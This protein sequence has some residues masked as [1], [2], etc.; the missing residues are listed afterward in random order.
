MRYGLELPNGGVCGDAR[1][2]ADLAHRAEEAGWDG[3]FL[4]DYITHWSGEPS[5][6][7]WVALAAMAISTNHIRLGT[8]VTPLS[9]RRPWKLARETVTLDHL[10]GG[11]LTLGVGIGDVNDPGY[12]NVGEAT[13]ARL[14]AAMVD[15]ALD[16]LAGLWSGQPFNY[17]GQ[18]YQVRD[19]TFL[20]RPVQTPRIPIWVGGG[21][22][23]TGP[24]RR[25]AR[26]DGSC[27]YKVPETGDWAD[28][29]PADIHALKADIAH[30]R[31]ATTPYEIVVGGRKRGPDWEQERALIGSL[32]DA[33]ATWWIEYIPVS[34][35][36]LDTIQQRIAD[37]PLRATA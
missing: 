1:I 19:L 32:A 34:F 21:W 3:I 28:M 15:E 9:R 24:T 36:D 5:C 2:L 8:E 30:H 27:L 20:P 6:D 23:N 11:R 25:A 31:T 29:T 37:G 17:Q 7:P 16:I 4:E 35:G 10:S 33:G 14:R 26:W 22:P 18:H 12:A 13:D